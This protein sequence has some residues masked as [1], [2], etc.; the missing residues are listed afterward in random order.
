[1]KRADKEAAK[2][3]LEA[4]CAQWAALGPED[5]SRKLSLQGEIFEL[6]FDLFPNPKQRDEIA[7]VFLG[8]WKGFDPAKG[9]A[10]GFFSSRLSLRAKDTYEDKKKYQDR[11]VSDTVQ[12]DDGEDISLL[13]NLPAGARSDP[14]DA[15]QLD[16]TACE[17]LIGIL[18]LPQRLRGRANN[19]TRHNY[20]RMF[21]TDG[22][23]ASFHQN[24]IPEIY[25]RRERDLFTAMKE[26]FLDFFMRDRCRTVETICRSPLKPYG[27]LVEGRGTEETKLPLPGDVYVSYLDR[28]EHTKAG[29]SAVSQQ[30][31]AFEAEV[32]KWLL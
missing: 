31:T 27:D 16:A 20:F 1:M 10:Y 17:L 18:D 6:V 4:L 3:R 8:D 19:P 28:M 26:E 24:T 29:L 7:A 11:I 22:I 21:F 15:L 12:T 13:A 2:A 25:L 14:E 32:R 9:S 23:A 5:G 30:R